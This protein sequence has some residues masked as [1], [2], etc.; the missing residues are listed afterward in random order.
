MLPRWLAIL[1]KRFFNEAEIE[2]LRPFGATRSVV[3]GEELFGPGDRGFDFFV[4]LDGEVEITV[5]DTGVGIMAED[6]PR[7]FERF[8]KADRA[9]SGGGTGL[10]LAIVKELV[11]LHGG[12]IWFESEEGQGTT[13]FVSLPWYQEPP[14]QEIDEAQA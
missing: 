1:N 13:F 11:E 7:I 14:E 5:E 3:D 10:G 8:F 9:R 6:L 4:V 2:K 12:E